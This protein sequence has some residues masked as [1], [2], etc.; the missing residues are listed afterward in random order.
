MELLLTCEKPAS[1]GKADKL[2]YQAIHYAAQNGNYIYYN[3]A[4]PKFG[5]YELSQSE[6]I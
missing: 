2:G 5:S 4:N 1:I 6:L 3:Y